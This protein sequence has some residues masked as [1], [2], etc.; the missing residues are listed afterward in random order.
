MH[1][2]PHDRLTRIYHLSTRR[3]IS[4]RLLINNLTNTAHSHAAL[5][6]SLPFSLTRYFYVYSD[7]NHSNHLIRHSQTPLSLSKNANS[8]APNPKPPDDKQ[9]GPGFRTPASK[10]AGKHA[11]KK[12]AGFRE[13]A[14]AEKRRKRV[15]CNAP[16]IS[17]PPHS[18]RRRH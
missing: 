14:I 15:A 11:C 5:L 7:S 10:E 1:T 13:I 4:T 18:Q 17:M 6:L 3:S 12:P 2:T 9:A 16:H 8:L